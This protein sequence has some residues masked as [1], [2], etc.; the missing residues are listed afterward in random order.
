MGADFTYAICKIP[1]DT[2]NTMILSG[3]NLKRAVK[4]RFLKLADEDDLFT[5]TL[6]DCGV[7]ADDAERVN[8]L[9]DEIADFLVNHGVLRDVLDLHLD[10][11]HYFITGGM[12]WGDEP[13]DSF[14]TIN[15]I[16]A[17]G[18]TEEPFTDEELA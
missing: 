7:Y 3:D 2:N 14:P 8:S 9:A 12:S 17:L 11:K 6:E 4:Q 1:V 5:R 13:T 16:D 15:L 10:G 18:I